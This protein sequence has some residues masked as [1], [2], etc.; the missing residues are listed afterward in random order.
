MEPSKKSIEVKF[1]SV[2]PWFERC[3][4]SEELKEGM[5]FLDILRNKHEILHPFSDKLSVKKSH[6][7]NLD[8]SLSN[9]ENKITDYIYD[10]VLTFF[11]CDSMLNPTNDLHKVLNIFEIY[12]LGLKKTVNI[13]DVDCINQ[14]PFG[15][16]IGWGSGPTVVDKW[17]DN[18]ICNLVWIK[19][20]DIIRVF[21]Y[22]ALLKSWEN[23]IIKK[24][25][26]FETIISEDIFI[27]FIK[28]VISN[29]KFKI[30]DLDLGE[31]IDSIK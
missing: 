26:I 3:S 22:E 2:C 29:K 5:T 15:S 21:N 10:N 23:N 11:Q 8:I 1:V 30:L 31:S 20:N 24:I 14:G 12:D 17:I 25:P 28:L 18:R 13:N 16:W 27:E 7:E 19:Q 4:S 6:G 9:I